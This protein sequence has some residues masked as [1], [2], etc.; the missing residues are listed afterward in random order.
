MWTSS[1]EVALNPVVVIQLIEAKANAVDTSVY[2]VGCS[3][4]LQKPLIQQ[5][6]DY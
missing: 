3:V 5:S 4:T 1:S 2:S 6:P